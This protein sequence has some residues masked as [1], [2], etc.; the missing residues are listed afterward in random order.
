MIIF[1]LLCLIQKINL[2]IHYSY[3]K[4]NYIL[5]ICQDSYLSAGT[6]DQSLNNLL[7]EHLSLQLNN[8]KIKNNLFTDLYSDIPFLLE[9]KDETPKKILDI[10]ASLEVSSRMVIFSPVF[11]G[12]FLATLKNTLDWLSLSYNDL[13][14]NDLFKDKPVAVVSSVNG[15][16]GNAPSAFKLLEAQLMNYGLNTYPELLLFT[17]EDFKNFPQLEKNEIAQKKLM[18]FINNFLIFG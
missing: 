13:N 2:L 15:S 9:R 14:Y 12:G 6:N 5:K 3:N 7:A 4:T 16:G 18:D 10:R 8:M 11:N 17:K 1:Q